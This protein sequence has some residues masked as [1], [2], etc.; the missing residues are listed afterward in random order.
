M[1]YDYSIFHREDV[2]V[3]AIASLPH[4]WDIFLS[5]HSTSDR[6]TILESRVSAAKKLQLFQSEYGL[7]PPVDLGER[8]FSS[9]AKTE[10]DYI[11]EAFDW[12][13]SKHGFDPMQSK[14]CVD[15]TGLSRP[16][17]LYM[18]M[19]LSH[20]GVKQ[21]DA[22]YAEPVRYTDKEETTFSRGD[23]EEVRQVNGFEGT[24]TR[25]RSEVLIIG[26]GYDHTLIS[27]VADDKDA[28][29]KIL[30]F[31]FPPLRADM[32]Q[33]NVLRA[34]RSVDSIRSADQSAFPP[35]KRLYAPANDPFI[36]ASVLSGWVER[37]K[38]FSQS[39]LYLSPLGTK[40]QVLG[41][42][43]FYL[44]ECRNK[45]V[46]IIYPFSAGYNPETSEGVSRVQLFTVELDF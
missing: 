29:E 16:N 12:L 22:L 9:S 26:T 27:E 41:F 6:V 5:A 3:S 14:L 7:K 8:L 33:E 13:S 4:N 28:A 11:R 10:A 42:G 40:V 2:D 45:D 1:S 43:L 37:E 15:I 30:L 17:I 23:V 35:I 24:T 44:A 20:L 32:Y 21:F 18:L 38:L 19:Y 36:T 25:A 46:S 34:F 31:G 39:N